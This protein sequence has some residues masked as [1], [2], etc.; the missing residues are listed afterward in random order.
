MV[1]AVIGAIIAWQIRS[2]W[3]SAPVSLSQALAYI[4]TLVSGLVAAGAQWFVFRTFKVEADWWAP[5]TAAANL[6]NAALVV[7]AALRLFF[8][9]TLV[10]APSMSLSIVAGAVALGAAGLL[11]G[12]V[13]AQMLRRSMGGAAALWV[14]LTVLGGA[15][16][17]AITTALSSQFYGMPAIAAIGLVAATG[18]LLTAGCQAPMVARMLR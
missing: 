16:A 10:T 8:P 11:T 6:V 14:P 18:S 3:P 1:G 17:G 7:P 13:Q 12:G 2:L 4:A 15:L 5:V 9:P